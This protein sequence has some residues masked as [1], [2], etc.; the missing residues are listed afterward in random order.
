M[1]LEIVKYGD[2]VLRAKGREVKEID[3]DVK[4]L[5]ADM[6]ET[7]RAANGVGLAAQ[8]I[9]HAVQLTVI[10]VVDVEDRPSAMFID[11]K[12][13][14]LAK[15]MPLVLLNPQLK[16]SVEKESG[17]EGCLSFPE[18]SAE[19]T[20]ASGVRCKALLLDGST[21]EFDAAGLLARALQHEVDHLHGVLFIDRMSS[22]ARAGLAGKL[23][24]LQRESK[25]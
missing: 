11:D 17:T 21:I 25:K 9:G 13:V 18:M 22:A 24:R 20:R 12:E 23:K 2:P 3:S 15:H 1:I 14:E 7:M 16:L 6:I 19:I 5:A 4:Q 8:Q 10:D